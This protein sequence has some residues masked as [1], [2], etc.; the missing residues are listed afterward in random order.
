MCE[1][2]NK[3]ID[4]SKDM[5]VES[6]EVLKMVVKEFKKVNNRIDRLDNRM[7]GMD[8]R[9]EHLEDTNTQILTMVNKISDKLTIEEVE[10]KAAQ[11]DLVRKL[12]TTKT[13]WIILGVLLVAFMCAGIAIT[14]MLEHSREVAEVAQSIR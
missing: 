3:K 7:S 8:T 6:K 5:S 12:F 1:T 11:M 10:K 14:Y 4:R 9:F 13:G 2:L